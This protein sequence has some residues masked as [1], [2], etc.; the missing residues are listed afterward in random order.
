M[1]TPQPPEIHRSLP[2]SPK[3][4]RISRS[5]TPP[6]LVTTS[7]IA[8]GISGTPRRTP[9]HSPSRSPKRRASYLSP[10]KA[11]LARFNPSLL[12]KSPFKDTPTLK[13]V[14]EGVGAKTRSEDEQIGSLP[15]RK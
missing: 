15:R 6:R 11:S 10:T 4:R 1:A 12:P 9:N 3:R 2:P 14:G 7:T 8:T 5:H 13:P